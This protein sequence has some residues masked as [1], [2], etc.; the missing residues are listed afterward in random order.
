MT[1]GCPAQ[2]TTNDQLFPQ[3]QHVTVGLIANAEGVRKVPRTSLMTMGTRADPR[4][5]TMFM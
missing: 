1:T 2:V 4:K 5:L 3:L